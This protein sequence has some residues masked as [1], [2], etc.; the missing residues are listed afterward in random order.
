MTD[1]YYWASV[2]FLVF[3]GL[4]GLYRWALRE[5]R[6]C[7]EVFR[8]TGIPGPPL[9]SLINGNA[10][11]FWKPTQIESLGRWLKQYGDVFG[12][13]LGTVPIVVTKDLN[14]IKQIMQK[15]FSNFSARGVMPTLWN[16]QN[17]FI[18]VLR[19]SADSGAEVN[20]S[21]MCERFTFD[22]IAKTAF[23]IDTGVQKNPENPLFQ[24]AIT[25]FPTFMNEF[26]YH[27]CPRLSPEEMELLAGHSMSV[28][29]G[30]Y[31]TTRYVLTYWFYLMGRHPDIQERMRKEALEAY[32]LEGGHL[33]VEGLS[34][35]SYTNQVLSETL[36][37]Y[38]PAI[39]FTTRCAEEDYQCGSYLIRKGTSVMVPLYQLHHDPLLWVD[40]EKFDPDRFSPENKHLV[41]PIAYQPFGL[42]PRM[43][44][45]YRL[46]LRTL[47]SVTTQVLQHFQITLGHTQKPDLELYTYALMAA[48]KD[49]VWVKLRPLNREE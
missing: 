22:V 27:T 35:L 29:V 21:M 5:R 19:T 4:Y 16:C 48:P 49:D 31:D 38:P 6:K 34:K 24:T 11:A 7:F 46:G 44:V 1:A 32:R 20:I 2:T 18:E 41:N 13:F 30:G 45:G 15:D 43:C 37:M 8:D 17:E 36:R 42:G 28:F 10:D 40:P 9:D 47:A 26:P 25:V 23:G 14:M 3:C 39:T 12:F 33:S